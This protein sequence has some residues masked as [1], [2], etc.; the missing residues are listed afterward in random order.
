MN[1]NEKIRYKKIMIVGIKRKILCKSKHGVII[2][3][4]KVTANPK[5]DII[6]I[7]YSI[8]SQFFIFLHSNNHH[9]NIKW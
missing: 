3:E 7:G 2:I 8:F 4:K 1:K 6:N 9:Q 5:Y